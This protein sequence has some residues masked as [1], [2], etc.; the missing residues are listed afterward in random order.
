MVCVVIDLPTFR[1]LRS[2]QWSLGSTVVQRFDHLVSMRDPE[3]N[4]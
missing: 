2:Q 1:L 4:E 3:G